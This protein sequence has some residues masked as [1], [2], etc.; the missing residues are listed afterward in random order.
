[1]F[2]ML[3]LLYTIL[4]CLLISVNTEDLN[5]IDVLIPEIPNDW[6]DLS[7]KNKFIE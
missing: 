7:V 2:K 4:L 5:E 3:Q 6:M 1:M